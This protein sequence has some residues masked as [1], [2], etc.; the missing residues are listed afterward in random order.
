MARLSEIGEFPLIGKIKSDIEVPDGVTG[1]G[2]DCAVLPQRSGYE[3]VISTDMLIEG[4][5]FLMDGI[6]PYNLGWKS[7]AVNLSDIAAMGAKPV[8]SFLSLALPKDMDSAWMDAFID[9]YKAIALKYGSP[10]LGGDTTGSKGPVCINVAVTGEIPKGRSKLRSAAQDGDLI[11]VTGCL[12]DS[13]A[14]LHGILNHRLQE[15][16][17]LYRRHTLPEPRVGAGLELGRN[18]DVHAMMDISDGVA[19]DLRHILEASG[20]GAEV[21]TE[22]I[23]MSGQMLGYCAAHGLDPLEKALCGG[24]D[25]ELLFTVTP[26]AERHLGVTHFVIGRIDK[27]LPD[28]VWKHSGRDYSGFRHF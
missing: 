3:T 23:P 7:L 18:G 25:Y 10:L 2:D 9:G 21:D 14:G 6:T 20:V 17:F 12:G 24:E 22:R 27:S 28:V 16:D 4:T 5:H 26:E 8:A 15:R 11:C 1:I 19:S 13:A